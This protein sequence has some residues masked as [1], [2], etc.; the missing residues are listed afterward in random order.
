MCTY[1]L[2]LGATCQGP[3]GTYLSSLGAKSYIIPLEYFDWHCGSVYGLS[4]F[5]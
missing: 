1:L 3:M 5:Y 2:S 4:F